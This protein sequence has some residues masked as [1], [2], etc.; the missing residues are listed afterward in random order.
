MKSRL[1]GIALLSVLSAPALAAQPYYFGVDLGTSSLSNASG[2]LTSGGT[3]YSYTFPNPGNVRFSFGS[4]LSEQF[5]LEV[6]YTIF[7]DSIVDFGGGSK[8]TGSASS[9]QFAGIGTL[10][11]NETIS[12]YGK[13]GM[14]SNKIDVKSE[15]SLF[16]GATVSQSKSNL[17]YGIGLQYKVNDR[18]S[19]RG[20]FTDYG[21]A[22]S[23][24]TP[25]GVSSFSIGM[26]YGF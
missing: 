20:E 7:G 8:L 1:M 14:A 3:T 25:L 6:G 4:H 2:T 26:T 22:S 17:F 12:A 18:M 21:D 16:T 5:G 15:G 23:G 11:V 10:P 19:V 9:F 24:N 13:L